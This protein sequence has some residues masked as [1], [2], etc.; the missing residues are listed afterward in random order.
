[1]AHPLPVLFECRP[2]GVMVREM[3]LAT[4][5]QHLWPLMGWMD[6]EGG[7][8]MHPPLGTIIEVGGGSLDRLKF[9]DHGS[10]S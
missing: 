4:H 7:T 9:Q 1:M 5:N 8:E 2:A 6:W 10:Q 3:V